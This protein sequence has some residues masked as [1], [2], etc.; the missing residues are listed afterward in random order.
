MD[1]ITN[2]WAAFNA[3]KEQEKLERV[4]FLWLKD[5]CL[6]MHFF[7]ISPPRHSII[8]QKSWILLHFA[9]SFS[10]HKRQQEIMEKEMVFG[11]KP[12]STPKKRLVVINFILYKFK[13]IYK[14]NV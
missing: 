6:E 3:Q 10:K 5:L 2:Q 8:Q 1:I 13:T 7:F 14:V 11:S 12:A 4:R 9:I